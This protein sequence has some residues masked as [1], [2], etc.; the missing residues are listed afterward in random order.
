MYCAKTNFVKPQSSWITCDGPDCH[1]ASPENKCGKCQRALY[2]SVACQ[3]KAWP[4]HKLNCIDH[5]DMSNRIFGEMAVLRIKSEDET[6]LVCKRP[7]RNAIY[8]DC[9]HFVCLGCVPGYTDS[10]CTSCGKALDVESQKSDPVTYLV[11]RFF[12]QLDSTEEKVS[13]ILQTQA[14]GDDDALFDVQNAIESVL[15]D[16]VV[17]EELMASEAQRQHFPI[18]D[19]IKSLACLF[20]QRARFHLLNENAAESIIRNQHALV[21]VLDEFKDAC[22]DLRSKNRMTHNE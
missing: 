8:L 13:Y 22:L 17:L 4:S 21:A 1:Q 3:K 10:K 15:N 7:G 14:H 2:C 11:N 5:V 9:D 12:K 20:S 6:C 19:S 16:H 18:V